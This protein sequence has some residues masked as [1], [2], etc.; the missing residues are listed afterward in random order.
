MRLK[1]PKIEGKNSTWSAVD[2]KI[3]LVF[4]ML[5][6]KVVKLFFDKYVR[7]PST[8]KLIAEFI[9]KIQMLNMLFM[10]LYLNQKL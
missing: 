7:S 4:L 2:A 9:G 8:E 3:K 6:Q 10:M 1:E 5:L